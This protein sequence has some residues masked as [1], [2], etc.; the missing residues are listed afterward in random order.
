LPLSA[1]FNS[2]YFTY[3]GQF[4]KLFH[5]QIHANLGAENP[6]KSSVQPSNKRCTL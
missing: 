5:T 3:F 2:A 4:W 6:L 1:P